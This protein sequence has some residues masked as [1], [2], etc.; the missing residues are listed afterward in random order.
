MGDV[1][2]VLLVDD[3][4]INREVAAALLE[5]YG[6]ELTTAESGAEAVRLARKTKFRLIFMD[7]RMPGMDGVEAA[8]IIR[9]EC[10]D[11]GEPAIVALT[12]EDSGELREKF[13]RAGFQD[14]IAKP[15]ER[16]ALEA[17]LEKWCPG[18]RRKGRK[19]GEEN[20]AAVSMKEIRISG[21]DIAEAEKHHT[22]G[23]ENYVE[24][25]RLYQID[26][27]R[28]LPLL[29]R[30]LK[31][32]DYAGYGV[33]VHAL[34]SASANLGAM[35]LSAQ[36]REQEEAAKKRDTVFIDQNARAL[37]ENYSRQLQRIAAFLESREKAYRKEKAAGLSGKEVLGRVREA[38]EQLEN[39][40]SKECA[41]RV[42]GLLGHELEES[43][44]RELRE[45]SEQLTVYE[46]D[47]AELLLRKL[48]DRLEK[49]E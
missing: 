33:E 39:F 5:D 25:L 44:E 6:L 48:A 7:H 37:L 18:I 49:E 16:E 27:R 1:Y 10:G 38:L 4:L 23:V 19:S 17:L 28:K 12:A 9:R 34:K 29:V 2:K 46:D 8:R 43:T 26:G 35:E 47:E 11:G 20:G 3:N 36:A 24:L 13:L 22:G 40:R 21:I 30:L 14:M 31:E 42:N 45:I 32:K 15:L 41:E